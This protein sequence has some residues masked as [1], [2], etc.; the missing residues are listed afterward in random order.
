MNVIL[1]LIPVSLASAGAFLLAFIWSVRNGQFEDTD[2]PAMRI[3]GEDDAV[4]APLSNL[5]EPETENLK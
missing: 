2:T 5:S 4:R 1:I 3:L